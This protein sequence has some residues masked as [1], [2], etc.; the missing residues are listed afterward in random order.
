M[1]IRLSEE[2]AQALAENK[3]VVALESTVISHGLPYPA[4]LELAQEMEEIV[5][6]NGAVPGTIALIEGQPAVGLSEAEIAKL[7][8]ET[9][10]VMKISRRDF[11]S[12]HCTGSVWRNDCGRNDDCG[13]QSGHQSLC[14]GWHWRGASRGCAGW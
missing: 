9:V 13:T 10:D 5:R 4:N 11:G 1:D 7:A 6:A 14:H 12:A 8:D 3:P 2:V